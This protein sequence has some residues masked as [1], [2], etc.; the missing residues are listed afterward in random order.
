MLRYLSGIFLREFAR[1]I[2]TMKV[3][4]RFID[5]AGQKMERR[6]ISQYTLHDLN[7]IRAFA[8][9]ALNPLQNKPRAL[10]V[11]HVDM[12]DQVLLHHLMWGEDSKEL[13]AQVEREL[14]EWAETTRTVVVHTGIQTHIASSK[15]SQ[16]LS[17]L[18]FLLKQRGCFPVTH[19]WL[20]ME[21][22][23]AGPVPAV[24][25]SRWR[26]FIR[27]FHPFDNWMTKYQLHDLEKIKAFALE[28]LQPNL[29]KPRALVIIL[30]GPCNQIQMCLKV[31]GSYSNE[32]MRELRG[33]LH[34]FEEPGR[35]AIVHATN[36]TYDLMTKDRKLMSQLNN[37]F[38]KRNYSSIS[39]H[40]M[41]L[42]S[43][44]S[45]SRDARK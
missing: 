8:I 43:R 25:L 39:H 12:Q 3:F 29:E 37:K 19:H 14:P 20:I 34:H 27:H 21:R 36:I 10:L 7:K 44:E 38:R 16:W 18:K 2:P 23:K 32:L 28:V 22:R 40:W 4:R 11:V 35:I 30:F 9:R 13:L 33:E 15:D 45:E 5:R 17:T 41:V 26:R 1:N 42:P 24:K 6:F 31:W